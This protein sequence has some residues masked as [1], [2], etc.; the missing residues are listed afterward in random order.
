MKRALL[1][2]VVVVMM[3][4]VANSTA[5]FGSLGKTI[6]KFKSKVP[7][8]NKVKIPGFVNDIGKFGPLNKLTKKLKIP[9]QFSKYAD[10]AKRFNPSNPLGFAESIPGIG[11]QVS[12]YRGLVERTSRKAG[13]FFKTAKKYANDLPFGGKQIG[14]V[15]E[16]VDSFRNKIPKGIPGVDQ[17]YN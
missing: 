13:G 4:L 9:K 16:Q 14:G 1:L 2:L 15:F 10:I 11:K 7:G 17:F 8:L 6:N 5:F 3:L 12:K